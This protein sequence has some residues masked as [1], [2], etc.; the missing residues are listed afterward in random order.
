VSIVT[1][2]FETYYDQKYSVK[3]MTPVEYCLD[4]RFEVLGAG[5]VDKAIVPQPFWMDGEPLRRYLEGLRERE[6][7]TVVSH[8]SLFDMCILHWCYGT[9][10]DLMIDTMGMARAMIYAHTGSVSLNSCA[11]HFGL[12]PKGDTILKVAGMRRENIEAAGLWQAFTEY[13]KHDA[14]LCQE[15]FLKMAATFPKDEYKIMDMVLRCAVDPQFVLDRDVLMT[16]LREIKQEKEQL[17]TRAGILDKKE[18]LSNEKFARAL[19]D[20]GIQPPT[21]ISP[22]TGA[23]TYAFAKSD[24]MMQEFQ[25][26]PRSEVQALVAARVG[27]KSTLEE[28]RTEKLIRISNLDWQ[29]TKLKVPPGQAFAPIPLRYSGAHTHRLSG[30]WKLNAQNWTKSKTLP[31][32]SKVT[33]RLRLA[34]RAPPG[35]LVVK[36]DASQIEARIVAWLSG[37]EDLVEDFRRGEDIYSKFAEESIYGYP[38]NKGTVDERFVGKSAILG[39]GFQVGAAKYQKEISAKSFVTLGYSI[40]LSLEDSQKIVHA[41]RQRFHK[42]VT[43]WSMCKE[44]LPLMQGYGHHGF[45]LFDLIQVEHEALVLPN[46]HKLYYPGL[47]FK[48]RAETQDGYGEWTCRYGKEWKKLFGGKV[49]E[50]I[51]QALARIITMNA[52]RDMARA[53]YQLAHQ[54]HDDLIYVVPEKHAEDVAKLLVVMMSTP[55]D[56]YRGLP[57]AAEAGIGE[58][59]GEC[60]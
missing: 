6:S 40:D 13:A 57:L 21:K 59:Y 24:P 12:A 46:G 8:N 42:I 28:T 51:V 25:K 31:D 19:R 60:K 56:W 38:V 3:Q 7:V 27:I 17:L 36:C 10:P 32:G 2:D 54:I 22:A 37:Q 41:Y 15:I 26:H 49:W 52:A 4:P 33:G 45:R 16:H 30:D 53:G 47:H 44:L 58:S 20:L 14:F 43:S 34:H 5:I 1:I 50:N 29:K 35:H 55:K 23:T 39:L 11:A 9:L 18:L 48:D